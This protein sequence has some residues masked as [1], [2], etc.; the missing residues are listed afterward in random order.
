M[1]LGCDGVVLPELHLE[2]NEHFSQMLFCL[3]VVDL[4]DLILVRLRAEIILNNEF[5]P[6]LDDF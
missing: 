2:E 5:L 1:T 4:I 6:D 3:Q